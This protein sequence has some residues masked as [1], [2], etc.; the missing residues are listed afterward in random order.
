MFP[1]S[2]VESLT[3]R[4]CREA[5]LHLR[6]QRTEEHVRGDSVPIFVA[7]QLLGMDNQPFAHLLAESL[8][9]AVVGHMGVI[10]R[11]LHL[12]G[13]HSVFPKCAV[14]DQEVNLDVVAVFLLV[15]VGVEV[16]LF[17]CATSSCAI[18][19]SWSMPSLRANRPFITCR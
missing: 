12:D 9:E 8:L 18:A 19:F 15:V 7:F 6:A 2:F 5:L 3:H 4:G 1:C 16:Q 14:R 11:G 10:F 17:P 13:Q